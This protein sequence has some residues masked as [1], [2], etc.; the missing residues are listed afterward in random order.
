MCAPFIS[1]T[2]GFGIPLPCHTYPYKVD[3]C[4]CCCCCR[5]LT[6]NRRIEKARQP[7]RILAFDLHVIRRFEIQQLQLTLQTSIYLFP[8]IHV[9][10]CAQTRRAQL[11]T[12]DKNL[13]LL[14]RTHCYLFYYYYEFVR[15]VKFSFRIGKMPTHKWWRVFTH[16]LTHDMHQMK[17]ATSK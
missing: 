15:N 2:M 11:Q 8:C 12:P 13:R 14:A 1:C 17:E 16:S 4:C 9:C 6:C 7:S 3:V 10:I 5:Q